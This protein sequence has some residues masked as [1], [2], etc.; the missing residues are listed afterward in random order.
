MTLCAVAKKVDVSAALLSMIENNNHQPKRKLIVELAEVLDGDAD[1]WCSLAGRVTPESEKTF[2]E[3]AREDPDAYR[4]FRTLA[5][6][7]RQ[8]GR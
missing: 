8:G 2:A 6:R 5:G 4:Y 3:L 1:Y 7:E